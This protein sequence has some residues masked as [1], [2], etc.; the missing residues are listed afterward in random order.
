MA[1]AVDVRLSPARVYARL[2]GA[3]VR[4]TL[5]YPASFALGAVSSLLLTA[6]DLVAIAAVFSN[7]DELAGWTVEEVLLLFGLASTGFY[8]TDL[9]LGQ[10]DEL[11]LLVRTGRLDVLLLRPRRVLPQ[12]IAGDVDLRSLGKVT[13][14][15]TVLGIGLV[16]S[17][18][19]PSRPEVAVRLAVAIVGAIAIY[20]AIWVTTTSICFWLV[21]SREVSSAF[22][23][24]GREMSTYPLGVYGQVLRQ[25]ARFAVPLAFTAYYPALGLLGRADP[26]GGSAALAWAGPVVGA[27]AVAV[28]LL[29]WRAGLRAYRSTGA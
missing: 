12:I 19:G 14:A 26:L 16:A 23:Y 11:G 2:V 24:G 22:T 7:V 8:L 15:V 4:S 25:I 10:L 5:E 21:D 27:I 13:Q 3:E 9:V 1:E 20:G 28:A 6:L 17:D 29:V 18:L